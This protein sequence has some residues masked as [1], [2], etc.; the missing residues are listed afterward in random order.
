MASLKSLRWLALQPPGCPSA[1]PV[2]RPAITRRRARCRGPASPVGSQAPPSA[3]PAGSPPTSRSG[4][5]MPRGFAATSCR[6]K[7]AG[8]EG[9]RPTAP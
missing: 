9:G 6:I 4:G 3:I 5:P 7:P 8:R 2:A 1:W